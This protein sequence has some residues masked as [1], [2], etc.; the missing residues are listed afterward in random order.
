MAKTILSIVLI[1]ILGCSVC[2][3]TVHPIYA[4]DNQTIVKDGA[5][6]GVTCGE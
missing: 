3:P 1:S 5:I 6:L 4:Y 2:T